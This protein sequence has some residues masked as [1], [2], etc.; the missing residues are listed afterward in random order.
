[1][2]ASTVQPKFDMCTKSCGPQGQD[3][4]MDP[5]NPMPLLESSITTIHYHNNAELLAFDFLPLVIAFVT[6]M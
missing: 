1:M 4:K 2:L 3:V 6:S 5:R